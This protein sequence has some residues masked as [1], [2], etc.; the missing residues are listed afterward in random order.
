MRLL[1]KWAEGLL[2]T[3]FWYPPMRIPTSA[4][5]H[6]LRAYRQFSVQL[7]GA[8]LF[9]LTTTLSSSAQTPALQADW[10]QS[11]ING[12]WYGVDYTHSSWTA[13]EQ[14]GLDI[15][16]HLTS[17]VSSS[18]QAWIELEFGPYQPPFSPIRSGPKA[19]SKPSRQK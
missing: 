13:G 17:I 7:F 15:G 16:G 19:A 2:Y 6:A 3:P 10:I 18:E 8:G 9:V 1:R 4:A 11:P 5:A 12:H 14:L